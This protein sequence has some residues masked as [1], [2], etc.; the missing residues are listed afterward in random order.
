MDLFLATLGLQGGSL[1]N[2]ADLD[3]AIQKIAALEPALVF[4]SSTD[5]AAR[6][7]GGELWLT[8][9]YNSRAFGKELEGAPVGWVLPKEG[10]FGHVT[11][12]SIVK[13]S[14]NRDLAL[15]YLNVATS[16]AVQMAQSLGAPFG[17]TNTVTFEILAAYPEIH[18]RFP[19]GP[20][21]FSK[22]R[23]PPWDEVNARRK[24]IETRWRAAFPLP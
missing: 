8:P 17:P 24:D 11:C 1:D 7:A 4:Q 18:R 13:G 21:D 9:T 12:V 23:I 14:E 6:L 19:L 5:A 3:A 22:L 2:P 20:G 10:G 16:P 15:T